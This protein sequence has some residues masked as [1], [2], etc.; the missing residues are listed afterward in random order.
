MRRTLS[1]PVLLMLASG[2]C[3]A[4]QEEPGR[5]VA[6]VS[7]MN[8]DITIGRGDSGDWVAAAVNAPLVAGDKIFAA[9]ASR[10]E[11]QF[12]RADFLRLG[13][14]TEV[15]MADLDNQRY[16]LQVSRGLLTFRQWKGSEAQVEIDTPGLAIRPLKPGIYRV[17]VLE[18]GETQITVREGKA[19]IASRQRT[20]TIGEGRTLLA[21][22]GPTDNDV[23]VQE[24]QAA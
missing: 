24:L 23:E 22:A 6:R 4:Q 11:V 15:R 7:L 10:A 2:L 16:Q 21:R 8:G 14:N 17:E 9:R 19:E 5:G 13:E 3:A 1:I 20:E 12:D 18:N